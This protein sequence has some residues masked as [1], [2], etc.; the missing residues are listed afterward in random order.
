MSPVYQNWLGPKAVPLRLSE[1]KNRKTV[2]HRPH[3]SAC[4]RQMS[5]D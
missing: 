2:G 5:D 3:G 4:N 1:N